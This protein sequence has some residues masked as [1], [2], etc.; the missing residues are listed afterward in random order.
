MLPISVKHCKV[1]FRKTGTFR[2]YNIENTGE[3][4]ILRDYLASEGQK[5]FRLADFATQQFT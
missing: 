3:R 4:F 2:N 5:I 1:T